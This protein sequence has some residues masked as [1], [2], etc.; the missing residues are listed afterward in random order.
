MKIESKATPI[1]KIACIECEQPERYRDFLT[2]A[3]YI[4]SFT[5]TGKRK[6][7]RERGWS[8][9]VQIITPSAKMLIGTRLSVRIM[10]LNLNISPIKM[11]YVF[12]YVFS[13]PNKWEEKWH[14]KIKD[15]RSRVKIDKAK[16]YYSEN[17]RFPCEKVK[18]LGECGR[19]FLASWLST[20][21]LTAFIESTMC[22][23]KLFIFSSRK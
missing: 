21:S 17:E 13:S 10:A 19:K 20:K 22:S 2:L 15:R 6:E 3:S 18:F 7:E 4:I 1:F 23:E 14:K 5:S 11:N 9:N 16:F 8:K 12:R